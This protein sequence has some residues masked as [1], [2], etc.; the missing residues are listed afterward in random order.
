M[1]QLLLEQARRWAHL[2]QQQVRKLMAI[3]KFR[4][5]IHAH[6]F[7]ATIVALSFVFSSHA[8]D[9]GPQRVVRLSRA[10]GQ[11]LVAHPGG[12]A[13]ENAPANLPLQE[14]DTLATQA[15]R[16]ELE[17]ENGATA[18]LAENSVLQ[19]TQLEFAGS[20]R[21]TQLDLTQGAGTFYANLASQDSFRVRAPTFDVSIFERAEFRVDAFSDGASA[22]VLQGS[23]YVSTSASSIKLEKGQSVA[24]NQAD[25]NGL[26]TVAGLSEED[27]F[28]Q[29]VNNEGEMIRSGNKNAL[30]YVSTPNYYGL[31]DL[32][33]Y[34]TW[35]N[36]PGFGYGWRPFRVGLSWTPYVNGSWRLDPRLGWVWI[37]GEAW[38][39]MPYHFGSWLMSPG[40]G[41]IWVPGGPAG[42]RHWDPACVHWVRDGNRVGWVPRSPE[43][44]EGTPA[45]LAHGMIARGYQSSRGETLTNEILNTKDGRTV[46]QIRQPPPEFAPQKAPGVARPQIIPTEAHH[47]PTI[48]PP[49]SARTSNANGPI[50]FDR[51]THSFINGN[52]V[53]PPAAPPTAMPVP[54][55]QGQV[56]RVNLPPS[57]MPSRTFDNSRSTGP[58]INRVIP[59][60][61]YPAVPG[62]RAEVPGRGAP[63]PQIPADPP[64]S[65]NRAFV[66]VVPSRMPPLTAGAPPAPSRMP[67]PPATGPAPVTRTPVAPAGTMERPPANPRAGGSAP[68]Q[69]R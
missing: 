45:N 13:W 23:V 17:F 15:G 62:G 66:P 12:D 56:P 20:G 16:A 21:V 55:N 36:I 63:R 37:S 50:V 51:G 35:L 10:E 1:L 39:W 67:S 47:V 26:Q 46:A 25:Y 32:A 64:G 54:G 65:P 8:Q 34:G 2:S 14:G 18:Y 31:S 42:L 43:D 4:R 48:R 11:V 6:L 44:R 38:G 30:N 7:I 40:A 49:Q 5:L 52:E 22:Q 58:P 57:Q 59:R 27:N 41:W 53:R 69:R 29:W 28:D 3:M 33:I 9:V 61:Q 60:P 68:I 19:L 24:L